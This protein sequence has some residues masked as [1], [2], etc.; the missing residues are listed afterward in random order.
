MLDISTVVDSTFLVKHNLHPNKA[1]HVENEELFL[2][3]ESGNLDV[4]YNAGGSIDNACRVAQ[5]LLG[6]KAD[7]GYI[8]C[9]GNDKNGQILED[10][11]ESAGVV[12]YFQKSTEYPTGRCL[13]LI[14]KKVNRS[15]VTY[16]G[17]A[18]K[19]TIDHLSLEQNW[20]AIRNAKIVYSGAFFLA[21]SKVSLL[22]VAQ[23][24]SISTN[25]I[26]CFNLSAT[27][28]CRPP[29]VEHIKELI[30]FADLV[31]G[32]AEEA[33]TFAEF[34][35]LMDKK[36][37]KLIAK[38]ISMLPKIGLHRQ[39]RCVIITRG[40]DPCIVVNGNNNDEVKEFPSIPIKEA[41]I[42]DTNGAGDAFVGGLLAHMAIEGSDVL[43]VTDEAIFS[44]LQAS[45][46][47]L[48][49][50]GCNDTLL[51]NIP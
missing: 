36:D 49:A 5:R 8:G 16:P 21:C 43:K 6:K 38:A 18:N 46:Q 39:N 1:K 2:E 45:F 13:V 31:V 15:L 51:K 37:H 47:I 40:K 50:S 3:I 10:A 30:Q 35:L 4:K 33:E 24:C 12:T 26:F 32:N 9:L 41:H 48:K 20:D 7:V 42:V 28:L 27:F 23:F 25:K 29:H 11:M 17:A 19:F 22:K 34:G 44:G 14:T